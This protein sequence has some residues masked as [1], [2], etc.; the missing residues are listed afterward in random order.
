MD[1]KAQL[2]Y[3]FTFMVAGIVIA[4]I[5]AGWMYF[6]NNITQVLLSVP[7]TD[8]VNMS[9]AAQSVLVPVNNAMNGLNAI[10]VAIMMGLIIGIFIEAYYIRKAPILFGVHFLIWIMAVFASRY[11]ANQYE[12]LMGNDLLGTYITSNSGLSFLT[13]NL[14]Y[15]ITVIGAFGLIIMFIRINKDPEQ[16]RGTI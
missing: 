9:Y 6:F 4:G 2:G 5:F 8:F 13:L 12:I 15:I 1:K 16:S 11:V 10:S 7:S 14:P 3:L